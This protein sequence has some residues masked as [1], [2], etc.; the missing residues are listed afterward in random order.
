MIAGQLTEV[1]EIH[2]PTITIN[3]YGEQSTTYILN[4]TTRARQLHNSN[5]R[6]QI[7][8]EIIYNH[9]HTLYV[10]NYVDVK[11]YDYIKWND[12][13]YKI[14]SIIPNKQRME[15]EIKCELINE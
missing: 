3:E 1:I 15:L 4:C 7:N 14:L 2:R 10:R 5:S 6:E 11:E 9:I 12:K 13:L 8:D